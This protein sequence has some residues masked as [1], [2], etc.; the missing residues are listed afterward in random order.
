MAFDG[1]VWTI[2][3]I[4]PFLKLFGLLK[5]QAW[6]IKQL[7]DPPLSPLALNRY[8]GLFTF[9]FVWPEVLS[10]RA[11]NHHLHIHHEGGQKTLLLDATCE[12]MVTLSL[13]SGKRCTLKGEQ[14]CLW[15]TAVSSS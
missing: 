11:P 8:L 4:R 14:T 10:T 7:S 9:Q 2:P 12:V 3:L 6:P 1:H 5:R 13:P 15:L